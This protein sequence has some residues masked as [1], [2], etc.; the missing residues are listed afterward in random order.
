MDVNKS[1]SKLLVWSGLE[2]TSESSLDLEFR[3]DENEAAKFFHSKL[4]N[5]K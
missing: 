4:H 3:E 5:L 2:E 1:L